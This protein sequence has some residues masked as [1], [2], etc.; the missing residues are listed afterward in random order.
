MK[1]SDFDLELDELDK[2][3]VGRLMNAEV[4]DLQAF[5]ALKEYL[6]KKSELIK[7]G[8]YPQSPFLCGAH[9]AAGARR[10]AGAGHDKVT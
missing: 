3:S 7:A 1:A 6:S 10:T 9:W 4:F 8:S 2:K 5:N